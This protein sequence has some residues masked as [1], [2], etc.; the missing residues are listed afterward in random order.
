MIPGVI[1]DLTEASKARA[2]REAHEQLPH[3]KRSTVSLLFL[4]PADGVDLI[5]EHFGPA[6]ADTMRGKLAQVGGPDP[7]IVIATR[8]PRHTQPKESTP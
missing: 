4:A 8:L 6:A 1:P 2:M 7:H 5:A 3:V